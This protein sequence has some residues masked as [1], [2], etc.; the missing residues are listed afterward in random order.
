M[1]DQSAVPIGAGPTTLDLAVIGNCQVAA[2]IDAPGNIVWACWPR[3]DGDPV[4]CALLAPKHQPPG[5]GALNTRLQDQARASQQYVRNTAIVATTLTDTHG[6]E[7]RIVDFCPRFRLHN[8][9]FRPATFVRVIEP[10]HGRPVIAVKVRPMVEYGAREPVVTAGSHHLSYAGHDVAFRVTSDASLSDIHEG[11]AFVLDH[12]VTLV[13]GPDEALPKQVNLIAS[14]WLAATR[15]YWSDWV[16]GLAV[17]FDWQAAVIRAAITLKLCTHE[18]TGAVLAALTTSIPEAEGSARTWDYRFCWLRDAFFV[19]Q[20]LNR[21]GATRTMEGFLHFI[22]NAASQGA[23]GRLRPVYRIAG[24]DAL[25]EHLAPSLAGYRA[26][27]PVRVGNAAALQRQHDVYGSVVLAASQLFFDERLDVTG[28]AVLFRRLESLGAR[29]IRMFAEPDAGPWEFRGSDRPHTFSAVLC[30]AACDR[31]SRIAGALGQVE[32]GTKWRHLASLLRT[33]L[34]DR[35]WSESHNAFVSTLDGHGEIDATALLMPELGLL[36]SG[37][38]RFQ[39]T[40]AAVERELVVN[41]YVMRYRHADDL[42]VPTNAFIACTFWY[43]NA[44][45]L[46]GRWH[47]AIERFESVLARRNHVGILSEDLDPRTGEL[48]GNLPQTYSM[49]GL[50]SSAIRLSRPWESA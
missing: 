43:I 30:W 45:A 42:G 35:A 25:E 15:D 50:I 5:I 49:V 22:E 8:R 23:S 33:D 48:W 10:V 32:R 28:D 40:L 12:A 18:D 6:G 47:E 34:L 9:T 21:L 11:R 4:F 31:L 37:D 44:L 26:N 29:A 36:S 3:P 24:A 7:A 13:I 20:A 2:L 27:G 39:S 16:R 14:D 1:G 38:P 46:A 17:P 19:V 41:G